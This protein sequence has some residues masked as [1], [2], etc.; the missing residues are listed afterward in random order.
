MIDYPNQ[1]VRGMSIRKQCGKKINKGD[2]R[3]LQHW[4]E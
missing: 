1:Y 4:E 2:S 3:K